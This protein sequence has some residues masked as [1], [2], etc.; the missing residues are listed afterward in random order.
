M[1]DREININFKTNLAEVNK[2]QE[3]LNKQYNLQIKLLQQSQGLSKSQ[4]G[5]LYKQ[6]SAWEKLKLT[7]DLTNDEIEYI[8]KNLDSVNKTITETE[9]PFESML[10]S[11][12]PFG[13]LLISQKKK[14]EEL[15]TVMKKVEKS[16][17][18]INM[19]SDYSKNF[20]SKLKEVT[21]NLTTA[22]GT[23][24]QG[25]IKGLG[26]TITKV[27]I[28]AISGMITALSPILPIIL[29]IGASIFVLQRLWKNNVGGMQT[30]FHRFIGAIKDTWHKFIVMFD[31]LL[32]QLGPLF[33]IIFTTV[34]VPLTASVKLLGGLFKMIFAILSPIFNVVSEIGKAL[35]EPF[36]IFTGKS[37]KNALNVFDAIAN[38][39]AWIGKA[40]GFILKFSL[41]PVII[42]F[43]LLGAY[44][45]FV[46]DVW[47]LLIGKA[48]EGFNAFMKLSFVQKIFK[49]IQDA[50]LKTKDFLMDMIAPFKW[51][52]EGAKKIA[53]FL[54][55]GTKETKKQSEA[56][57][58]LKA[59]KSAPISTTQIFNQQK[60]STINNTAS[61]VVQSSGAITEESAPHIGNIIASS[62]TT[63]AR[64]V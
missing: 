6:R 28:P 11:V 45:K 3:G 10:K 39:L 19:L 34:F 5:N 29:A 43:K 20:T 21:K 53:H 12:T 35:L 41:K 61:V 56:T 55:I 44:I 38:S 48:K 26:M 8:N 36:E 37:G 51:L 18:F 57:R 30:Q 9:N 1:P 54:G 64:V 32:R 23:G 60:T 40:I 62:L 49:G 46:V 50:I 16:G 22:F 42:P 13:G 59:I 52:I 17:G 33:K 7:S 27:T 47:K 14:F 58:E 24:M 63:G 31:K 15:S 25:M 2:L 4:L